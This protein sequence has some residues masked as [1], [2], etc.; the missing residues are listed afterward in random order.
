MECLCWVCSHSLSSLCLIFN[1][2]VC[3][4]Y[5]AEAIISLFYDS[6]QKRCG[7]VAVFIAYGHI[8]GGK[9]LSVKMALAMCANLEKGYVTY[10]SES[11][12]R[13]KLGSGLP[14]VIDD[15][16]KNLDKFKEMLILAFGGA[17][18]ENE[19]GSISTK[20][21]PLITANQFIIDALTSDDPR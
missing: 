16:S 13:K 12:G 1:A 17:T 7:S 19:K 20:C 14:F 21:V 5:A 4:L 2:A 11:S 8:S 10:I 9:S 18:L 6:I 15:P 3:T